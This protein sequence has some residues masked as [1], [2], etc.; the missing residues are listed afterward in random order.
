MKPGD[1][2]YLISNLDIYAE[3][4]DEKV[5]NNIP[6][7]NINVHRGTSKTKS[8]LSKKALETFYQSSQIPKKSF[9]NC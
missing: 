5:M 9:F 7:F 8:C 1:K 3:I 6:H 4:L 2:L